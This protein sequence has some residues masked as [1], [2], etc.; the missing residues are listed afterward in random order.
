MAGH[1]GLQVEKES[2]RLGIAAITEYLQATLGQQMVAFLAGVNSSVIVSRWIHNGVTP[3]RFRKMRLRYAYRCACLIEK[4]YGAETT[5]AWF[6]GT[7]T[8]LSD[9]AP[10][11]V[12]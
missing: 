3:S 7:N 12:L 11:S 5:R 10:A 9:E 6:Y 8:Q 1:Q 4:A 2:A